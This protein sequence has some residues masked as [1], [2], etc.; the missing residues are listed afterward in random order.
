MPVVVFY[1]DIHLCSTVYGLDL[2]PSKR[3]AVLH[4]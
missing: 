2:V 3:Y 1:L 4:P